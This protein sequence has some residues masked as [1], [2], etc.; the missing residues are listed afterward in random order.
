MA[1]KGRLAHNAT[2]QNLSRRL[3]QQGH[4][5]ASSRATFSALLR[6]SLRVAT[7]APGGDRNPSV[8]AS[9]CWRS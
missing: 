9:I 4:K 1:E 2:R 7:L 6:V 5:F 8:H 3:L